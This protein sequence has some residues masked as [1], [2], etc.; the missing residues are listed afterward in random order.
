[1][2]TWRSDNASVSYT[3]SP[4]FESQCSHHYPVFPPNTGY[5]VTMLYSVSGTNMSLSSKGRTTKKVILTRILTATLFPFQG[6][7]PGFDS[8][9]ATPIDNSRND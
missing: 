9:V 3:V 8:W 2:G 5:A 6:V 4:E 7:D 1:M